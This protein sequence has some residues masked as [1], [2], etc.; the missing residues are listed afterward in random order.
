VHQPAHVERDPRDQPGTDDHVRLAH[1]HGRAVV[2]VAV[3]L[4]GDFGTYVRAATVAH[5]SLSARYLFGVKRDPSLPALC[6]GAHV[7]IL[8]GGT[9]DLPHVMRGPLA[10]EIAKVEARVGRPAGLLRAWRHYGP[11]CEA[12]EADTSC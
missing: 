9:A 10:A 3:Y 1:P 12:A 4:A 6:R 5:A 11:D 2:K 7:E 8:V